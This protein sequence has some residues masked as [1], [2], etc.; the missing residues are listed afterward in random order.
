MSAATATAIRPAWDQLPAQLRDGLDAR[1]GGITAARTQPGGFTPGL[2]MRL[3][4]AEGSRLFAKGIPVSHVLA[5][6]YRG[7][8]VT[9]R[10]LPAAAPAPRLR[11]DGQI[12]GWIVLTSAASTAAPRPGP[13]LTRCRPCR[14]H[15]RGGSPHPGP[16]PG[17]RRAA[18]P[19]TG[20]AGPPLWR[21]GR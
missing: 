5:G 14:G 3:Q 11:W 21:T 12:A 2:A 1:P 19:R 15:D 20:R 6:K 9:C 8:A 4:P 18:R 13:G 16:V 17:R 7:E 10:Q